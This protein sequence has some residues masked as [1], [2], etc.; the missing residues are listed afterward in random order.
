MNAFTEQLLFSRQVMSESLWPHGLQHVFMDHSLVVAKGLVQPNEA[1]SHA[2]QGHPRW[3]D[4]SGKFWQNVVHW[5]RDWQTTPVFQ[6]R[7]PHEEY[8]KAKRYDT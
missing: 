8:E 2:M 3:T 4:H 6:P 5:R 7:E 1:V